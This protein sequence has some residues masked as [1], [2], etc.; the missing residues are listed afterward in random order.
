MKAKLR[1]GRRDFKKV[2]KLTGDITRHVMSL[3]ISDSPVQ[4]VVHLYKKFSIMIKYF[5][6]FFVLFFI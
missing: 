2:K 1:Q 4:S 5:L 3:K 6:L